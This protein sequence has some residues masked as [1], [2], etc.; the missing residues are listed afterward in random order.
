M[1]NPVNRFKAALKAGRHQLG[2]WNS[3]GGNTVPELLAGCG[4]DW[5]L[6]DTEHSP[7]DVN[8]VLLALQAIA[9]YPETS[10][11]VRPA[12]NDP[13]LIKRILDHGAQTLLLPYI[14][15]QEEAEAAVRAVRYPPAGIRGV[16]GLTRAS[17]YGAVDRYTQTASDEICL[18]LQV[19]TAH[20]MRSLEAIASVDGVDGIFIGPSDL[21]ASMG[22][23][24][25]PGHPDVV[26]AIETAITKLNAMGKPAGILTLDESFARRC[27]DLGTLFTAVA[28]DLGI[29]V[30]GVRDLRARF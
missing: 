15:S 6:V 18:L 2:I 26:A 27:M 12:F 17:R 29:L 30:K 24:G 23:P 7:V 16:A 5:V 28:V 3:I 19:E 22:H 8:D 10:A 14:Q 21:A 1:K 25:N 20:A 4:F 11:I 9:G 13:V